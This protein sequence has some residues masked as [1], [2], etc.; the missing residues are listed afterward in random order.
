M[1]YVSIFTLLLICQ[2]GLNAQ[3]VKES[4]VPEVVKTNFSRVIANTP[5]IE[6]EMEDGN[7]EADYKQNEVIN[8]LVLTAD[9]KIVQ[10]ENT[11]TANEL[12]ESVKNYITTNAVGKKMGDMTRIKTVSGSVSYE[13]EAGGEDYLFD[14]EGHFLK[15]EADKD[16]DEK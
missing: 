16:S 10:Y 15:K 12:P 3:K 4:S 2:L 11:I 5:V 14:G 8:T 13:V 6:W 9:G 7:Y 1:K